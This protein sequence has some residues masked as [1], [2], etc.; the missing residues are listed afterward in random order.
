LITVIKPYTLECTE[1]GYS[2][3]RMSLMS[4]NGIAKLF[5]SFDLAIAIS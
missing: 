4:F 3:M 2:E 1:C 5:V